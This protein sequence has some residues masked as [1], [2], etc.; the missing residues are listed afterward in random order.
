[1]TL[2][3]D[4]RERRLA[5]LLDVPHLVRNLA[6][7]DLSCN[8]GGANQWIAERKTAPDLA[9]SISSGRWRDQLYRL[10]QTGCP[11]IFLVEGDL[12]TTNLS[13]KSLM[14]ACVNAELRKDSHVIRTM[15]LHETAAVV[16]HLVTKGESE[17]RMPP[18]TLTAPGVSKRERCND[19]VTCWVRMLMCCPTVSQRIAEKLLEEYGSLPAIQIALQTPKTFKRIRLDDRCCIGK[20]RIKKLALYLTDSAE[21]PHEQGGDKVD[22]PTQPPRR[23][24]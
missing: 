21:E 16:R 15:D 14:G 11:V 8:Y 24:A 9:Q 7:G 13:Y 23:D 2:L 5:Q 1:M 10:H 20:E 19:R 3:V 6:V 17:P 12:R 4:Y 18:S 22:A